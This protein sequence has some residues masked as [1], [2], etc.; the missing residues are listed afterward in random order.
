MLALFKKKA[1]AIT[2]ELIFLFC[3]FAMCQEELAKRFGTHSHLTFSGRFRGDVPL[4][5]L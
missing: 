5:P 4:Q 1:R 2:R 3:D